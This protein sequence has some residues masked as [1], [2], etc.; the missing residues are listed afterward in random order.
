MSIVNRMFGL[1]KIVVTSHVLLFC[2]LVGTSVSANE[3]TGRV[4]NAR[5]GEGV[6]GVS[7]TLNRGQNALAGADIITVFTGGDGYYSFPLPTN[8]SSYVGNVLQIEKLGYQQVSPK[9]GPMTISDNEGDVVVDFKVKPEEN[10]ANNAPASAWL[11]K[12]PETDAKSFVRLQCTGCHQFPTPRVKTYSGLIEKSIAHLGATDDKEA[13]LD[14]RKESWSAIV[15][16]MRARMYDIFPDGTNIDLTKLTWHQVQDNNLTLFNSDDGELM[17][18]FLA[19]QMP[20]DFDT[21]TGYKYNAPLGVSA[22]TV[23]REYTL[24]DV[25]FVREVAM[26]TGSPYIWGADLQKN[27]L[28][29]LDPK[30]G[31][32]KWFNV[33]SDMPTGPHTIVGDYTG[34]LWIAMMEGDVLAKYTPKGDK[35]KLWTVREGYEGVAAI[36]AEAMVHDLSFDKN[37][38][39]ARDKKGYIW[40]TLIGKNKMAGLNPDT[41]EIKSYPAQQIEGRTPISVSLYGTLLSN[42]KKC[43]WYAQLVGVVGCFNTETLENESII[44]FPEGAGPR[45]LAIDESDFLWIPLFGA[46]QLVKY[47]TK[48]R[49]LVATYDLPDRSA[50]PYAVTWDPKRNIIWCANSNADAIYGFD[51]VT[52][53]FQI[54]PLPRRMGYLRRI[55]VDETNGNLVTT[56]ANIPTGSGPSKVIT[57]EL[58]D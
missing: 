51:P 24:P 20:T 1:F 11:S 27:R 4:T 18:D 38:K 6:F 15:K 29:R 2:A 19:T 41:G 49:K 57:V 25:S 34:N 40:L 9:N 43:A 28:L 31:E 22:K 7:V 36:G 16:Y 50:A 58:G 53:S 3:L 23:I 55:E 12:I 35:W 33:P 48:A 32:K 30:T 52:E 47:D 14:V 54:I 46:G 45:R 37:Y 17:S 13:S 5:S 42:D 26:T 8:K 21:L 56:Y 39:L 44:E 10:I